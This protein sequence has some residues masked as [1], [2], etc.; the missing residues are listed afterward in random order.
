MGNVLLDGIAEGTPQRFL[1][2]PVEDPDLPDEDDVREP[3]R[4]L[5]IN[6]PS[7][8]EDALIEIKV[9][10]W[11]KRQIRDA[12]R[13][14]VRRQAGVLSDEELL[15]THFNLVRLKTAFAL[16]IILGMPRQD[17]RITKDDW[18]LSGYVMDKHRETRDR[19]VASAEAEGHKKDRKAG[20]S[21]GVR[22]AASDEVRAIGPVEN[23][24]M[25]ILMKAKKSKNKGWITGGRLRA[26]M[27]PRQREVF[28]TAISTLESQG[29]VEAEDT[30]VTI[31]NHV[32]GRQYRAR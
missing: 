24:I 9:P 12:H 15:D 5:D 28:D 13:D 8:D 31:N 17:Y 10:G 11:I 6:L 7:V 1:F 14:K 4:Q 2:L 30:I 16:G 19:L 3:R 25:E 27:S 22:Y 18:D 23:R 21:L 20:K 32:K 29:K 26:A